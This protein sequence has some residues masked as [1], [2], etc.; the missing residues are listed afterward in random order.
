V[1]FLNYF[2]SRVASESTLSWD[3]ANTGS[4]AADALA[5]AISSRR[6]HS[7]QL[8]S[9][10][11]AIVQNNVPDTTSQDQISAFLKRFSQ[12]Y[13]DIKAVFTNE[14]H[15]GNP[16]QRSD[17]SRIINDESVV[18]VFAPAVSL[19]ANNVSAIGQLAS[20]RKDVALVGTWNGISDDF[21][22]FTDWKN[23]EYLKDEFGIDRSSFIVQDPYKLGY[24][25]VKQAFLSPGGRSNN[26]DATV[27]AASVIQGTDINRIVNDWTQM[28]GAG[29]TSD[30][31][32]RRALRQI[33]STKAGGRPHAIVPAGLDCRFNERYA[34]RAV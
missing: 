22:N 8:A 4:A 32:P 13:P 31:R 11:I 10:R 33:R 1:V 20:N 29:L 7:D 2:P 3:N 19:T 17:V 28:A 21:S 16:D 27:H 14:E 23:F 26:I 5:A 25:A 30:P 9:S 24:Q 18:G 34:S 6:L 12:Q 15:N